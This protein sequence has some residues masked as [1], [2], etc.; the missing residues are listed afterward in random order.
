MS[1]PIVLPRPT[2]VNTAHN[3]VD[4]LFLHDDILRVWIQEFRS[5]K[6]ND[7]KAIP[8]VFATPDRAF[9]EMADLLKRQDKNYAANSHS[10]VPLPF[11]SLARTGEQFDVS[12]WNAAELRLLKL[13]LDADDLPAPI[14]VYDPK[15]GDTRFRALHPLPWK[16]TYQIDVWSR[17]IMTSNLIQQWMMM[18]GAQHATY[19]YRI[20]DF[21][22]VHKVYGQKWIRVEIDRYS[23]SSELEPGDNRQRMVR[24]TVNLTVDAWIW[25]PVTLAKTIKA[26][27][28]QVIE[29]VDDGGPLL[30]E[31]NIDLLAQFREN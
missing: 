15:A 26:A 31:I 8:L 16:F 28:F 18:S 30:G 6:V 25:R 13:V 5:N 10:K 17:N 3:D 12:R 27:Q 20:A 1:D 2:E 21:T 29:G 9:A 19:F 22:P 14:D 4:Q 23:D 7:N 11:A 24:F